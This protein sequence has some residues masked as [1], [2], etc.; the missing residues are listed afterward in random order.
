MN[1]WPNFVITTH[2]TLTKLIIPIFFSSI[3]GV[4]FLVFEDVNKLKNMC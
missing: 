1:M 3:I 2:G 4:L